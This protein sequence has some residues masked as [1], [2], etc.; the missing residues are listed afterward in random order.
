MQH[1]GLLFTL[2]LLAVSLWGVAL[3]AGFIWR[4]RWMSL[5]A[6][7]VLLVTVFY[8]VECHWGLGRSLRGVGL[9]GAFLSVGLI[10]FSAV[11]WVP[12]GW[13]RARRTW[14]EG[15]RAELQPARLLAPGI[16]M[17]IVFGYAMVWRFTYPNIDGSSEKLADFS[18]ICSYY[19]GETLPVRDAWL[20]PYS[21]T[22]YYSFMHYGAALMGRLLGVPPGV[23][24]NVGFCLL[25]SLGG[26]ACGSVVWALARKTWVRVAVLTGFV[27]GGS[28]FS[29]FVH[30]LDK[31][32]QPWS[33]MRFI[34]SAPLDN[35]NALTTALKSYVEAYPRLEM[36]GEPFSY[37]I[38]LGD[39][40][41]PIAS[42]YLLGLGVLAG[43]LWHR[44]GLRRYPVL[45]GATLTWSLLANT[46]SLPLQA[47]AVGLWLVLNIWNWRRLWT[48]VSAG[49][50]AIWLL[51]WVYLVEFTAQAQ[52]YGTSIRLVGWEQHAPPLL[53]LW[54]LLPTIALGI[55]GLLS[56]TKPG[57]WLGGI[58]LFFVV[59]SEFVFVDD[60]YSGQFE[61]FNTTLKWW[62]W[63]AAGAL[64]T[65][66]PVVLEQARRKWVRV[67]A[68]VFCLYPCVFAY[69][70]AVNWWNG[71]KESRGQMAGHHFMTKD[72]LTKI[73][74]ER[75]AAEPAGVVAE[76]P[77]KEAFT[78]SACVP[79]FAGHRMW[80]G[81]VGHEAL[82]RSFRLDITQRQER[83]F[84]LFDGRMENASMWLASQG[85]DYVLWYQIRDTVELWE[86]V[87]RT[88][89]GQY[90]WVEI[91]VQPDG[92]RCGFWRRINRS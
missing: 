22:H 48:S 64:V 32:P 45:I 30:L 2:A 34:G 23:A 11:R 90:E 41:A 9:L 13:S 46:W 79:L 26:V 19:G 40:H 84:E 38:F 37:S 77:E 72:F 70:L 89:S 71:P 61:R 62:P 88:V 58:W 12:S 29:G 60:V 87:N 69:D 81:W 54:F 39:Y 51:A 86:S 76:R 42:Y 33:S 20:H 21:S 18:Y 85:I 43:I 78:N 6:G 15:W 66:A 53:F 24:Y 17:A 91:F 1:L 55:L 3:V 14:V 5:V 63:I 56:E 73:T 49:A 7:P 47:L 59:V 67:A 28:G 82:W 35:P 65:I 74:L 44:T 25:I 68:G 92:R 52:G 36:P 57:R 80:L 31:H 10:W 27:L 83:L 16:V 75:L 50:A 4:N 8:A